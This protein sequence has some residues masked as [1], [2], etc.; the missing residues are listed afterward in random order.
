MADEA[1]VMSPLEAQ[2]DE[3]LAS[4]IA[5]IDLDGSLEVAEAAEDSVEGSTAEY[6]ALAP[7]VA[8]AETAETAAPAE[9]AEPA[10]PDLPE[11]IT[12]VL[13]A[14]D[15]DAPAEQPPA[16]GPTWTGFAAD[17]AAAQSAPRVPTWPFLVYGALCLAFAALLVWQFLQVPAGQAV[18]EAQLYPV[19]LLAGIVLLVAGPLL[20][21]LV[22]VIS[23]AR[24]AGAGRALISSLFKGALATFFGAV[25][26][27]A[28]LVVVDAVRLGRL[29]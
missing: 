16:A 25:L 12:A 20:A 7:E 22:W 28:A 21:V 14:L 27:W 23:A 26:W 18:Y 15:S 24:A 10:A 4:A 17:E 19:S 29:F 9:V 3:A 1:E 5:A 11:E 13:D 2:E 8:A 6:E